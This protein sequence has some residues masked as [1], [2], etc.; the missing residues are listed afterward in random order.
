MLFFS[1][2]VSLL[3]ENEN[4]SRA[5]VYSPAPTEE[6]ERTPHPELPALLIC[7]ID[8]SAGPLP[9]SSLQKK[10]FILCSDVLSSLQK[11]QETLE[12]APR[13]KRT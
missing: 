10:I 1:E 4:G 12:S 11:C 7:L 3:P 13:L 5:C 6:A 9:L 2:H 8:S